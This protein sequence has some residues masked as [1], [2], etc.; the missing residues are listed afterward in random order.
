VPVPH[1]FRVGGHLVSTL[2]PRPPFAPAHRTAILIP[3]DV[4]GTGPAQDVTLAPRGVPVTKIY[5][6]TLAS[7]R[8]SAMIVVY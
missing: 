7:L 6:H 2:P 4:S 3:E 1:R 8:Q 5:R